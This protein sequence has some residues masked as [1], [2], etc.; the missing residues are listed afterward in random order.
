MA[1]N[2]RKAARPEASSWDK[3]SARSPGETL[4]N[5]DVYDNQQLDRSKFSTLRSA[6]PGIVVAV[7]AGV[8]VTVVVWVLY[9][10]IATVVLSAGASAGSG[11]PGSSTGTP[12]AYYVQDT[13]TGAGG[14]V[15]KCYRP[16]A[17]D[18]NPDVKAGCY[19]SAEA[20][21]VPRWY[22]AAK[23]G[24]PGAERPSEPKERSTT[25]GEQLADVS[26]FKLFITLGS[27]L[28][29][30]LIIGTWFSRKVAAANLMN[31]TSDINQYHNDQHIALPE[32]IQQSYDW[33]PDA[34]AHSSVQVSS[35][36]SHMMLKKKGLGTVEVAQRAEKDVIDE[37]GNL[38]YYAGE[39]MD[40]DEGSPRTQTLPII[41]E[42]FGDE[43]FEASGLPKDKGLR[44]KYDTKLIPYNPDGQ[45]R[46]KLGFGSD[47][48]K[49][50]ADLIK[51]D[52]TFPA[53]EVQRPAG[54]YVVDTAPVNT[55]VLA[56]TRAGKG[57]TYIEPVID[58]WSREKKPSNMVI[59]DPKGELLVKSYVP[60]V[61][62][63]FEPVQ[64]NLVNSMKTDIY[65]ILGLAADAARE[66]NFT[67]CALYVEN[68]A[69]I[70]FPLDGGEDPVWPN[71]ANNA[72]KRAAYGLIDFY[73]E[74]ER[75][76]RSAAAVLNM[77]L[78]L[79]EQKL[80]DLW[81]KVTLY[82]CY[83]LF[84]QMSSKK[85][86]NPEAELEKRVKA[87]E[88]ENDE[89]ALS[90]EQEKAAAQAF[91]WEGKA[92]QDM[93]SLYFNA[94]E[95]LPRNNMRTLVGN[96]HNALRSMA[97]AEKMLASVYGIAI[98]AM[99]FFTDPTISTLTSGKPSQ[100]TDLAGLSF[101]RRLG[102]RFA[103]NYVTR[104]H[105]VGQQAVW[106]A[107]ADPLFTENLGEDFTHEEIVGREGWAR[108]VF[109]GKFPDDE[110]WLKL[111]LVN[112]QTKML[113]RT[114][115]FSFTKNYRLSLN[116]RHYVVEPVTGKKIV[117]NGVLRELKRVREGGTR[118]GSILSFQPGDTLY[119]DT[120]LDFSGGGNPEKVSYQVRVITQT[121]ARYSESPKALFLVTPPHLM[122][123]A[124]LILI[125]VKQL[126]DVSADQAY[127]TKSNQKPLYRTRFMLDE[128]GN[129]QSEGK[130]IDGFETML[131][132]G[133]GQ[134]QQFT[135]IL[136][137]LQQLRDV[138]GESVDKIVQGNTSNIVFLKSTDDSMIETLEK[139]SG[140][141]HRSY[142]DSKQI[143]QDLDKIIG[144]KTEG[145]VS[146]TMS[147]KEEPLISY[148]DMAF[149]A[150]RN[151][152]VFRAGDAPIWNRNQ[153]ILP[154]SFRLLGN[155]IKHP[156]HTYSLQTIPTLSSAMDFDVR[157]NQPDFVKMLEKRMRQAV[158][159]ADANAQ[160]KEIYGY[161]EVD[162]AR[163]DPDVYADEVM[164]VITTMTT[165]DEGQDPNA[166]VIVDPD[167]Y[168]GMSMFDEDQFIENVEVGV[169][170][171]ESRAA[172]V[173]RQRLLYAEGTISKEMLV[174]PDGSAKVKSLDIEIGE[175][176]KSAQTELEQDH[177]HFSVG[178]DGELRSADGSRTY[179]SRIRSDAYARAA[180]RI[181]GHV[182]DV[183]SRVFA[184]EDVTEQD[185]KSLVT[186]RV[187][188]AFYQYLASLPSWEVLADG[189][190]DRAMAIE[191]NAK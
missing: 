103:P 131:S 179:I 132:I 101:P 97:G 64:F 66:G 111:E 80:D 36:L 11:R 57:Q 146:Y 169:A 150:P 1:T 156:G 163:L 167:E 114:F 161:R 155:T 52:W 53:Y 77:D 24:R 79:V 175:A 176:Y 71:A 27:G 123:Y 48:Y 134:E 91:M 165:V 157:M 9:S 95:E 187:H 135:L 129:L 160:Y 35:M 177:G 67:K 133:L 148:N 113:V 73:L 153:T 21:P 127:M 39:V 183:D 149:L 46:D 170:V 13:T 90:E 5:R 4:T 26:G 22:T 152:I 140:K 32:E 19:P 99:S 49:T 162:I 180:R 40:D 31:D 186:V 147:T 18:G 56:I 78:A 83:Q 112:P 184:E 76:L 185:L 174:N 70:F 17:K 7:I 58:M 138:Y 158:R 139:M 151:S 59:N 12:S 115:Y 143:S 121:L 144:G 126:F 8:L 182:N 190:F 6:R 159:A 100:N 89:D 61:T 41:D 68:I 173:E 84:V 81:G 43:L 50:V 125:L 51:E 69:G 116:G 33:F 145:R 168:A 166:P 74:E 16:L 94:S 141:T 119:P 117:K 181:N 3:I 122:K 164:E 107:Y 45:N 120:R 75:E 87:G 63:G 110:A 109:K 136:Q 62:R 14:S 86:K 92:D 98:T 30:G 96:A 29:V 20:V 72:F 104:D 154:M 189:R 60:L 108:Y 142:R 25:V 55:M 106:S 172:S 191:M 10:L 178:G 137:T 102:V 124:K 105:L 15:V 2:R 130:G 47:R 128:L 28:M 171:A 34:G 54:A 37:K 85:I 88:F 118:D 23:D 82:N 93:L 65:N 38:V 44:Q 188:S 42:D